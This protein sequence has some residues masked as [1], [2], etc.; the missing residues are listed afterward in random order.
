MLSGK[1][2]WTYVAVMAPAALVGG[3]VGGRLTAIIPAK[4]L[5]MVVVAIGVAIS[6]VYLLR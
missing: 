2:D 6:L 3:A 1:V 5:R 4:A